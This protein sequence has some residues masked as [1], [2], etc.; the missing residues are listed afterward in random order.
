MTAWRTRGRRWSTVWMVSNGH[1]QPARQFVGAAPGAH[2]PRPKQEIAGFLLCTYH[3]KAALE[4]VRCWQR[5]ARSLLDVLGDLLP[6]LD[7]LEQFEQTEMDE[8]RPGCTL[9]SIW[10][11]QHKLLI[12]LLHESLNPCPQ[13]IGEVLEAQ[14][15]WQEVGAGLK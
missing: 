1:L 8:G 4:G 2:G 14:I 10:G 7:L 13:R 15:G 3:S 11:L 6:D 12:R 9:Q 5:H